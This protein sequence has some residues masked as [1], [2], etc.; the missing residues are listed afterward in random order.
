MEHLKRLWND[1]FRAASAIYETPE[2]EMLGGLG[3]DFLHQIFRFAKMILRDRCSTSC[4]ANSFLE[5]LWGAAM[6]EAVFDDAFWEQLSGRHFGKQLLIAFG[7]NFGEHLVV[8]GD[9]RPSDWYCPILSIWI[10]FFPGRIFVGKAG[11]NSYLNY[12]FILKFNTLFCNELYN[13]IIFWN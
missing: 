3:A 7:C 5:Q 10:F 12:S 4:D 13:Y 11:N 6:R 8:L 2:S 1:A 9:S